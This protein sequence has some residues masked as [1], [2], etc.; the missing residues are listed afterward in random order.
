MKEI[1]LTLSHLRKLI[2][3]ELSKGKKMLKENV[4]NQD[5]AFRW[6]ISEEMQKMEKTKESKKHLKEKKLMKEEDGNCGSVTLS[7]VGG[8]F[9]IQGYS[10]DQVKIRY[11]K[12]SRAIITNIVSVM[13]DVGE[14]TE[15]KIQCALMPQI[16]KEGLM[17]PK[18]KIASVIT[19]TA[20]YGVKDIE[21]KLDITLPQ[22]TEAKF[23]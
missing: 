6:L 13:G 3:E 20:R 5:D 17:P 21:Q 11:S 18:M 14:E 8:V 19:K 12:S 15:K 23:M 2:K 10:E 9:K 7:G 22:G 16:S 1:K 4:K